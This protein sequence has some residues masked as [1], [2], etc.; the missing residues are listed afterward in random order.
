MDE[1]VVRHMVRTTYDLIAATYQETYSEIDA[2]DRCNFW[3]TFTNM[4]V[5]EKVL[6]MGCGNGDGTLFLLEKGIVPI[7]VDFSH[8]MI[9]IACGKSNKIQ[10]LESDICHCPFPDNT[11]AGI[12]LA[13]TVN[14]LTDEMLSRVKHEVDRLL[15][16]RGNLLLVFHVGDTDEVRPDP[17]DSRWNIYYHYFTKEALETVFSNYTEVSY[18]QRASLD[19]SEL[20]NDKGF[21]T[22]QKESDSVRRR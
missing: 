20:M 21:L 3:G 18:S 13:Y 9:D 11:F 19:P 10:W 15:K 5:G 17:A 4:C 1:N 6:D 2:A 14:H 8:E 16:N 22:L 12:V 7:G